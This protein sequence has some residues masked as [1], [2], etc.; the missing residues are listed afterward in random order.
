MKKPLAVLS[1][2]LAASLSPAL[3][4]GPQAPAP[5]ILVFDTT[6]L[7]TRS[8]VGLDVARQM[9][10]MGNQIKADLA[11]QA[12]ALQAAE[13]AATQQMAILAPDVKNQKIKEFQ[14]K[15]AAIQTQMTKK[16][17]MLDYTNYMATQQI[18]AALEPIVKQ[19]MQERGAN[20]VLD[21]KA[22]MSAS[23]NAFDITQAA[24]DRLNQKMPSLK[25]TLT[26]PPA[27]AA[28]H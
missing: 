28:A 5:K 4:A 12:K 24:I 14:A 16:Q 26:A 15:E 23:D 13:A 1:F 19:L 25:V 18:S 3:A 27:G 2:V 22:V 11:G 9:Q 6:A 17:E 10:A 21:R 8:K 20:I 7:L